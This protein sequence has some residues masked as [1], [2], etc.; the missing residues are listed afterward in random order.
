MQDNIDLF[1]I[2]NNS[3]NEYLNTLK[4]YRQTKSEQFLS[5][6]IL[7]LQKMFKVIYARFLGKQ[8]NDNEAKIIDYI[9]AHNSITRKQTESLLNL[10]LSGANKVI[11]GLVNKKAIERHNGSRNIIYKLIG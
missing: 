7:K 11:Q 6:Y 3:R 8:Y 10:S 9:S 1:V 2:N 5:Q 4:M